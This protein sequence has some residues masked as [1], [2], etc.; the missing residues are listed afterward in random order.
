MLVFVMLMNH[1]SGLKPRRPKGWWCPWWDPQRRPAG[2]GARRPGPSAMWDLFRHGVYTQVFDEEG[3]RRWLPLP[4]GVDG[5]AAAG[6]GGTSARLRAATACVRRV[7]DVSDPPPPESG[8]KVHLPPTPGRRDGGHRASGLVPASG[9]DR[10][11]RP[12][13]KLSDRLAVLPPLWRRLFPR[14]RPSP[15][16]AATVPLHRL[17]LGGRSEVLPSWPPPSTCKGDKAWSGRLR[18]SASPPTPPTSCGRPVAVILGGGDSSGPQPAHGVE[19]LIASRDVIRRQGQQMSVHRPAAA[20]H[21]AGAG[22][23]EAPA[24]NEDLEPAGGGPCEEQAHLAPEGAPLWQ[25]A[26]PAG[27]AGKAGTH[28]CCPGC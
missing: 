1:E 11:V 8:S 15:G 9:A 16:T 17:R 27:S 4:Y 2:S 22:Y 21:P 19:D 20:H 7:C 23:A 13:G 3:Q 28:P 14:R 25:W 6:G 12:W 18:R 26:Y 10:G 24:G 5:G